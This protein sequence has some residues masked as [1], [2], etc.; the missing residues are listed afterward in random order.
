MAV[1]QSAFLHEF[2]DRRP[3][4]YQAVPGNIH[5]R[6]Y[7]SVT[8]SLKRAS[9]YSLLLDA[10]NSGVYTFDNAFENVIG[11]L[12]D[13]DVR[14][15][16]NWPTP[17]IG[18]ISLNSGAAEISLLKGSVTTS[19]G[20][21]T[22]DGR[23]C[24]SIGGQQEIIDTPASIPYRNP[25]RLK[26][27]WH[28]NGR[29]SIWLNKK[30]FAFRPGHA[31]GAVFDVKTLEIGPPATGSLPART[32][33]RAFEHVYLKLL[34]DDDSTRALE[35]FVPAD[36]PDLERSRCIVKA[37]ETHKKSMD[38]CRAF[39][40][41]IEPKLSK[42]WTSGDPDGP[43]TQEGRSAHTDAMEAIRLLSQ[44]MTSG[45]AA[46]SGEYLI[47]ISKFLN[48]IASLNPT[49]FKNALSE[50]T[51]LS[52]DYKA[53]CGRSGHEELEEFSKEIEPLLNALAMT[54]MRIKEISEALNA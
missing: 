3:E 34:R 10:D 48:V 29:L 49:G 28:T 39:M 54:E 5:Y 21:A 43:S 24:I 8:K 27:S 2:L 23:F 36:V 40:N 33:F 20:S 16:F 14:I 11:V 1:W 31:P 51:A 46:Q 37:M 35:H 44:S 6:K 4:G 18:L 17:R 53:T 15:P 22:M 12:V 25:V 41:S 47:R 32:P 7:P 19:G 38:I 26:I 45:N 42:S 30:L 52:E 50:I 9:A 13:L